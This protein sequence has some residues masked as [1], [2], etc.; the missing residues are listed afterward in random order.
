MSAS[1]ARGAPSAGSAARGGGGLPIGDDEAERLYGRIYNLAARM[2]FSPEDAE[3]AT[4]DILIKIIRALPSFRGESGFS[5]WALAIAA[6]HL[7]SARARRAPALSFEAYEAEVGAHADAR[8]GGSLEGGGAA[9]G[10]GERALLEEELKISC[11]LGML[12]CL[13]RT[14][15]LVYVLDAFLGLS[16]AEGGAV[17]GLSS[18]AYRQRLSRSRRR[19]ADFLGKACGL[20]GGPCS[21]AE[22]LEY[23]LSMGRVSR[24]ASY[25]A[26][27]RRAEG[28]VEP[29][30][31]AM[32]DLDAA[33]SLFKAQPPMLPE[34]RSDEVERILGTLAAEVLRE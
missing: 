25:V 2:L 32:E 15:R 7:R 30:I 5:T 18:E 28:R 22:R 20:G 33:G 31:A 14:D 1:P 17:S 11:T 26:A 12:Q 16:S 23:A 4:Q 29:F 3:D 13:D 10:E 21:C 9:L 6:N 19:M 34:N 8:R 24:S 27:A